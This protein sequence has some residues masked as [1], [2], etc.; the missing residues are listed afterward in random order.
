[1]KSLFIFCLLTVFVFCPQRKSEAGEKLPPPIVTIN[2]YE[3]VKYRITVKEF[4]RKV[5]LIS[6]KLDQIAQKIKK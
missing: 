3:L 2:N 5:N 1:M 6:D 4:F